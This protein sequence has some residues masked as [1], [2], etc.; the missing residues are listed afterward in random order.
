[1]RLLRARWSGKKMEKLQK[2]NCIAE[3][4]ISVVVCVYN[5]CE[6]LGDCLD[7]VLAQTYQNLE[8]LVVDDGS[9]DGGA[10]ICD[11]Y[12]EKDERVR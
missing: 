8:I 7:S 6:Y 11:A 1:M 5:V 3:E 9:A 12:A 10:E 2:N 4:K